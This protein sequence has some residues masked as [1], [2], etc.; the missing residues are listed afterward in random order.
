MSPTSCTRSRR[1]VAAVEFALT[2]PI[3]ALVL[4]GGLEFG[5]Y[6]SRLAMVTSAAHDAAAFGAMQ[7]EAVSQRTLAAAATESLLND[8][9]FDCQ[10]IEC[11]VDVERIASATGLWMVEVNLNVEYQQLTG[12][13]PGGSSALGRLMFEG[14]STLRARAVSTVVAP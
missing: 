5:W 6:F 2:F 9:G 4:L 7:S 12:V 11:D 1:G 8:M 10:A 3:V 14:P 13:I